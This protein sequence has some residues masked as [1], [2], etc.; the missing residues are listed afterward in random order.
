MSPSN[1]AMS[2]VCSPIVTLRRDRERLLSDPALEG[3]L[4]DD[5]L[6][7]AKD[8]LSTKSP[9]QIA[10]AFLRQNQIRRPTPEEFVA[11]RFR[12]RCLVQAL[13]RTEA[14]RWA[15][16]DTATPLQ[17]WLSHQARH[18]RHQNLR[19]RELG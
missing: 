4:N 17:G 6:G 19:N 14:E 5:E 7:F 16:L 3:P 15:A 11:Q 13:G 10:A 9:E 8:L 12:S 2:L 1:S 18:R